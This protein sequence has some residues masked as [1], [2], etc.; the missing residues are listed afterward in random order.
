M[1]SGRLGIKS[2]MATAPERRDEF[3]IPTDIIAR[4]HIREYIWCISRSGTNPELNCMVN[5]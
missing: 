3:M 5:F 4:I 1:V 2:G